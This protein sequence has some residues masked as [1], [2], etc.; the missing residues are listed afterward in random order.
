MSEYTVS[1]SDTDTDKNAPRVC[2]TL[3]E[4]LA[5][6]K[7]MVNASSIHAT[8]DTLLSTSGWQEREEYISSEGSETEQIQQSSSFFSHEK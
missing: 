4:K 2:D 6:A 3:S 8:K 1:R 7:C 5:Y